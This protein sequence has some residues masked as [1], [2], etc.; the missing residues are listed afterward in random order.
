[1]LVKGETLAELALEIELGDFLQ[2]GPGELKSGGFR[3]KS[4][5]SDAMEAIIAA[6]YIDG[7]LESAR[8]YILSIYAEK[9]KNISLEKVSKD[10]KTQLQETMQAM[11]SPLPIYEITATSGSDHEQNFE[12]TCTVKGVEKPV[13]GFGSSRR[14]AEQVAA[15]SAFDYIIN[16]PRK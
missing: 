2:L 6:I 5:L 3:R 9:L 11:K 16:S 13:K 8:Q 15:A 7:G 10:P 12:V 14:K 1:M 4:I